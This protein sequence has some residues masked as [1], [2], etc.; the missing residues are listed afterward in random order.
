MQIDWSQVKVG[1]LVS[2]EEDPPEDVFTVQARG[3]N[4]LVATFPFEGTVMYTV[5]DPAQGIRGTENLV[6]SAGAETV[7]QCQEMIARLE[8][9]DTDIQTE[10]SRRNFVQIEV[11]AYKPAQ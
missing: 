10:I 3:D 1:S 8:G 9:K 5:I 2:F 4:F 6:F 7:E 11:R